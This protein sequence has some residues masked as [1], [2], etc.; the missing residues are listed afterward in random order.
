VCVV[1][2]NFNKESLSKPKNVKNIILN[3]SVP[4]SDKSIK[5]IIK[6][7]NQSKIKEKIE[8]LEKEINEMVYKIYGL[9]EFEKRII[10]ENLN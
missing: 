8:E 7:V 6:V 3:I 4:K 2:L 5:E 1:H 10:E 9:T